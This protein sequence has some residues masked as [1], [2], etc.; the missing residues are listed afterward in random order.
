MARG[1]CEY[2]TRERT[3]RLNA[4]TRRSAI[5]NLNTSE[6]Q[7]EPRQILRFVCASPSYYIRHPLSVCP[8]HPAEGKD[9]GIESSNHQKTSG[10]A[11]AF[12][13]IT[14][15]RP[16]PVLCRAAPLFCSVLRFPWLTMPQSLCAI[17]RSRTTS[18][19]CPPVRAFLSPSIGPQSLRYPVSASG[20]HT[21]HPNSRRAGPSGFK[22]RQFYSP[23]G[24]G[25]ARVTGSIESAA[26]LGASVI[27]DLYTARLELYRTCV[28][29]V[30]L[31]CQVSSCCFFFSSPEIATWQ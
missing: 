9:G 12:T 31:R 5:L 19:R 23:G 29:L 15:V 25:S 16:F 28:S 6:W 14:N 26:V 10:W 13:P 22:V 27:D 7:K 18:W 17:S 3:S 2:A 24:S 11:S 8:G 21:A 1:H 30:H 20:N 4:L